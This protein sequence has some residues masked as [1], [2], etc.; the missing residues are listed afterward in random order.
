LPPLITTTVASY[1]HQPRPAGEKGSEGGASGRHHSLGCFA[2][3]GACLGL[4]L[5]MPES[6]LFHN[7][8]IY[9]S[10]IGGPEN[11]DGAIVTV[12]VNGKVTGT[13]ARASAAAQAPQDA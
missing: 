4:H 13:F 5:A 12:D 1:D 3:S 10:L 2:R 6:V 8:K 7:G 9:V 11:N